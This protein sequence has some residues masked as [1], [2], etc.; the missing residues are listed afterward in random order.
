M[1]GNEDKIR[2]L[3]DNPPLSN[4][5]K[6][7]VPEVGPW[8]FRIRSNQCHLFHGNDST[9]IAIVKEQ[10]ENLTI[11]IGIRMK[12]NKF[13]SINPCAKHSDKFNTK[14]NTKVLTLETTS[15]KLITL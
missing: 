10:V 7:F 2:M 6:F 13:K 4:K 9:H 11:K 12:N 8:M 1:N 14:A 5:M 3:N 15:T